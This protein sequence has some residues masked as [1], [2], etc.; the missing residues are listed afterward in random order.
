MKKLLAA[1]AI[2]LL[3]SSCQKDVETTPPASVSLKTS[4][5]EVNKAKKNH[6]ADWQTL[7]RQWNE[8]AY[9]RDASIAPFN[10]PDGSL[11]Y[12]AQP[13]A[14]GVFML[15]GG[16]SEELVKRTVTIDLSQYQYVFVPLVVLTVSLNP[17]NPDFGPK[18]GQPVE[19]FFTSQFKSAFNGPKELTLQWDGTSL[20]STKQ[21]DARA[22][23]GVWTFNLHPTFSGCATTS[24]VYAEGYWAKIPL[25]LGTHT[26]TV[27]GNLHLKKKYDVEFSNIVEYTIV[28]VP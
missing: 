27:G 6:N 12:L 8:W 4:G 20:L 5:T 22:N 10:D 26:L 2:P 16:S 17:C 24:A 14:E 3:L 11:Q 21:K 9:G 28:V 13:Y 19:A 25:S 7:I 1:I 23:S 15:A 18:N